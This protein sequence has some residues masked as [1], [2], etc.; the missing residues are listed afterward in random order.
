MYLESNGLPDVIGRQ[1]VE[2]LTDSARRLVD[3]FL[4]GRTPQTLR[5]YEQ[6]LEEFAAFVEATSLPAA[7]HMLLT[8]TAG[9]G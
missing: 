8:S 2:Y 3:A 1:D 6:S 5:T 9:R 4:S 7:V